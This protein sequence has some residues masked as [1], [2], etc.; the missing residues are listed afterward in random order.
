[1]TITAE[2]RSVTF[3]VKPEDLAQVYRFNYRRQTKK[4]LVKIFALLIPLAVFLGWIMTSDRLHW[5]ILAL[6]IWSLWL[7][8]GLIA[9]AIVYF[10][11][12]RTSQKIFDQQK[13]LHETTTVRW[14]DAGLVTET[15]HSRTNLPWNYYVDIAEDSHTILLWQSAVLINF[16]PKS[17]LSESQVAD[18]LALAKAGMAHVGATNEGKG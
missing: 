3:D 9:S 14:S 12:S 15:E 6:I 5:S 7:V 18:L 1:M 11:I 10:N 16:I 13:I 8:L 2:Q 4:S 17:A